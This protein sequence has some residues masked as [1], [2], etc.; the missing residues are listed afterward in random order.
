MGGKRPDQHNIA[1][2]EAGASDYKTLPQVG[3]GTSSE[4]NTTVLDKQNLAHSEQDAEGQPFL[5]DVPSPS[6]HARAG[7]K[8]QEHTEEDDGDETTPGAGG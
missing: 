1:P 4:D 8:V 2:G 3:K 6:V 7:E 5:P